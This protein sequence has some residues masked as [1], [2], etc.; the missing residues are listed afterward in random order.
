MKA[1]VCFVS[2]LPHTCI[3]QNHKT[4]AP[5]VCAIRTNKPTVNNRQTAP[6]FP[7]FEIP[8]SRPSPRAPVLLVLLATTT[9]PAPPLEH[10]GGRTNLPG[11]RLKRWDTAHA[12][13]TA[14]AALLYIPVTRVDMCESRSAA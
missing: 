6:S 10:S 2:F 3:N 12:L 9:L 11:G 4:R 14:R 5:V 13:R 7:S 8:C 1:L